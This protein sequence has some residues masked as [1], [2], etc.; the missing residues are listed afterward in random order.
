MQVAP[1]PK[2][3]NER[4]AAL[5]KLKLLDTPPEE[6]FDRITRIAT[7]LFGMPISTVTMVDDRRE[8]F[9]SVKGLPDKEGERAV[10]FC[11]HAMLEDDMLVIPDAKLDERFADNPMVV[12]KP[13]IRSYAGVPL[14][15]IDG[16]S[17]G[18][19]CVKGHEPRVFTEAEKDILRG[20]A[21]WAELEMNQHELY[22]ELVELRD[23][24]REMQIIFE[25]SDDL[26]GVADLDGYFKKVNP[27]F[28]SVLGYDEKEML[29]T[30]FMELIHPEDKETTMRE[31]GRL[32]KGEK[33][34]RFSVR[35]RKKGDGYVWLQWNATPIGNRL[36]SVARDITELRERE[37]E[38]EKLNALMIDR[39]MRMIELKER[40]KG[41]ESR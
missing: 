2:N 27:A 26:I 41:L 30:P 10:S 14:K 24:T 9:K 21:K 17:V 40:L 12:G 39:E 11:G 22:K 36:Y 7:Q 29:K 13:F 15:S 18:A 38:L 37:E 31:M 8:W 33:V 19:F 23:E 5:K 6:R 35:F 4:L 34:T 16:Q 25:T 1:I 20:L 3:E 28:G 32:S